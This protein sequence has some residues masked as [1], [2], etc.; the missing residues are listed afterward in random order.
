MAFCGRPRFAIRRSAW[1]TLDHARELED[2]ES[3]EARGQVGSELSAFSFGFGHGL[4]V[5]PVSLGATFDYTRL[6]SR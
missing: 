4:G 1:H 3:M 6:T 2:P 5:R